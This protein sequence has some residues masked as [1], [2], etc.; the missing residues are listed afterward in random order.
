MKTAVLFLVAVVMVGSFPSAGESD[1]ESVKPEKACF[2]VR[3][4]RGF[5]AVTD[6]FV[7]VHGVRSQH[8]LLTME[9][10][11]MGL[12]NSV[13]IAIANGF[14]RVCSNDRAM[15]TY[16]EFNQVK[17]CG[18]LTVEAVADREGALDLVKKRSAQKESGEEKKE[19]EK[20]A[21]PEFSD[22]RR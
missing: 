20:N 18:I 17:R 11:C 19:D 1:A 2:R 14:D 12:E 22:G 15:I 21:A 4:V 13:G 7:Y 3:D 10:V 16:K 8:Y 6:R 9:N 5:E